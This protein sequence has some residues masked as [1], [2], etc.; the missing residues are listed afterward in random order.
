MYLFHI[1]SS[2][3]WIRVPGQDFMLFG[4]VKHEK[5]VLKPHLLQH[6]VMMFMQSQDA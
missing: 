6:P 3:C 1:V 4:G 2:F 5:L